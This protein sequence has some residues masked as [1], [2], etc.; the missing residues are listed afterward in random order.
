MA[1]LMHVANALRRIGQKNSPGGQD[2]ILAYLNPGEFQQLMAQGG[3]G[4][5]DPQTGIPHLY[6]TDGEGGRIDDGGE[7][8]DGGSDGDGGGGLRGGD[9]N[10]GSDGNETTGDHTIYS[11]GDPNSTSLFGG[12]TVSDPNQLANDYGKMLGVKGVEYGTNPGQFDLS[13]EV[14]PGEEYGMTSERGFSEGKVLGGV[15]GFVLGGLPGAA[16]GYKHGGVFNTNDSVSIDTGA[17]FGGHPAGPSATGTGGGT[18]NGGHSSVTGT[19]G[20]NLDIGSLS[21][22]IFGNKGTTPTV[23]P[24][25]PAFDLFSGLPRDQYGS[26]D[27]ILAGLSSVDGVV[28]KKPKA[29]A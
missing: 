13:H 16:F 21:G 5:P 24:M 9:G 18:G 2:S 15:L 28:V 25:T 8:S 4:T 3:A 29:G 1:A 19:T 17:G 20:S 7:S 26:R 22:G 11:S 23:T 10:L 12:K 14:T 27:Q 6:D